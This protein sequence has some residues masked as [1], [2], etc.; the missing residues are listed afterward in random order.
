[1]ILMSDMNMDVALST[2][3]VLRLFFHNEMSMYGRCV[4]YTCTQ[5]MYMH[6]Q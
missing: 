4:I 3:N 5:R 2:Y 1:M 6:E